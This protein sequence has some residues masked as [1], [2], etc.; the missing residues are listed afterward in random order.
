MSTENR[1][2]SEG[3]ERPAGQAPPQDE[4]QKGDGGEG[5][6]NEREGIGPDANEEEILSGEG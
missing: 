3:T 6:E 4:Q 1:P 2:A 5:K